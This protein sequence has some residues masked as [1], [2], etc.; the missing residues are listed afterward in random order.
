M[1][2]WSDFDDVFNR[3]GNTT[4]EQRFEFFL[5][6]CEEQGFEVDPMIIEE[7]RMYK[8]IKG[9]TW[10]KIFKDTAGKSFDDPKARHLLT[11]RHVSE[12][13]YER[14]NPNKKVKM[15]QI[16]RSDVKSVRAPKGENLIRELLFLY[17]LVHTDIDTNNDVLW[18]LEKVKG[19]ENEDLLSLSKSI[20]KYDNKKRQQAKSIEWSAFEFRRAANFPMLPYQ[21]HEQFE[22]HYGS[23]IIYD[24][25]VKGRDLGGFRNRHRW[26]PSDVYIIKPQ[27]YEHYEE[28]MKQDNIKDFNRVFDSLVNQRLIYPLSLKATSEAIKGSVSLSTIEKVQSCDFNS[29]DAQRI[30]DSADFISSKI[31]TFKR[32]STKPRGIVSGLES[33]TI[34]EFFEN[35]NVIKEALESPMYM[36]SYPGIVFW[37]ENIMKKD[38]W[39]TVLENLI[40]SAIGNDENSSDF[41]FVDPKQCRLVDNNDIEILLSS[42]ELRFN[43]TS[44]IINFELKDKDGIIKKGYAD[45]RSKKSTNNGQ[46]LNVHL[47]TNR[48]IA[49]GLKIM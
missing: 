26:N 12:F 47:E 46:T 29:L 32:L 2:F 22:F 10:D 36:T 48:Q 4:K 34:K 28:L 33:K 14:G 24:I 30:Q 27:F 17:Y 3:N 23:K 18:F 31:K 5:R 1:A 15:S 42:V 35:P 39:E 11:N 7:F 41:W 8:G 6:D 16:I 44:A 13:L 25:Q 37:L 49:H 19:I 21:I 43:T 9:R 38:G 20:A 45:L 40:K